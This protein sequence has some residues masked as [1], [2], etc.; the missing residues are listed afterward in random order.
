[1]LEDGCR[2]NREK[3]CLHNGNPLNITRLISPMVQ[4]CNVCNVVKLDTHGR[5]N[6]V[7]NMHK[8]VH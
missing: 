1:M 2:K 4:L 6:I 5:M 3:K 8:I 7:R